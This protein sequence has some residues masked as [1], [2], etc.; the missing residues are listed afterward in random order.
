VRVDAD[1]VTVIDSPANPRVRAALR[2]RERRERDRTGL[3]LVDGAREALRALEAGAEVE[4]AFVNEETAETADAREVIQRLRRGSPSGDRVG[5]VIELSRRAFDRLAFGDRAEGVVLVIRTPDL[6]LADIVLPERPLIVVTEAVEK[7]G[8][9]G[10]ILRSADAVAAD[11]VLAA[12]GTDL[13]NP[14]VIRASIGTVFSVPL[15]AAPAEAVLPWLRERG[16]RLVAARVDAERLHVEMDLR[17]PLAIV[18]GG[19]AGGLSGAW[20]GD[21]IEA[22]RLPMLGVADSLN[23]SVATAVLLYEAWR[24]RR[25]DPPGSAQPP[26]HGARGTGV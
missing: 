5:P 26:G 9:L 19:E 11:A 15:A 13:F 6:R 8:N 23:V 21:D 12:G 18:V 16:I 14:N 24:Q 10:A 22:V 7:P 1:Q 2:L 17:G 4:T 3:S 20:R 25:T